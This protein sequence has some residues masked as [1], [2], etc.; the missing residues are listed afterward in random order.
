MEEAEHQRI[1]S[2]FACR[3]IA[4]R[5]NGTLRVNL[6]KS[7][8]NVT[9]LSDCNPVTIHNP[10][11]DDSSPS[12][13]EVFPQV[14]SSSEKRLPFSPSHL[15]GSG[16]AW[17]MPAR[18]HSPLHGCAGPRR[19]ALMDP[20]DWELQIQQPATAGR[21]RLE[22]LDLHQLRGSTEAKLSVREQ[23]RQ[24]EQKSLQDQTLKQSRDSLGSLSSIIFRDRQNDDILEVTSETLLSI[25]DYTH[26]ST[27]VGRDGPPMVVIT[28]GEESWPVTGHRPTP[29]ALRRLSSSISSCMTV[30]P[31]QI[32]VEIIPDPPENPPPPPPQRQRPPSP[33]TSPPS[34]PPSSPLLPS[35]RH[36]P[37]PQPSPAFDKQVSPP[38]PPP[39]PP[40]PSPA[41]DQLRPVVQFVPASLPPVSSLRPVSERKHPQLPQQSQTDVGRKKELKGIL[42]NIQNLA[43]I[44]RSVANMYSQVDKNCKVPKL[45]IKPQVTEEL[46][47]PNKLQ[48][49]DS[50]D[51]QSTPKA[52][53]PS[54]VIHVSSASVNSTENES[55]PLSMA[56]EVPQTGQSKPSTNTAELSEQLSSESTVF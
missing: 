54:S 14:A 41:S 48:S 45:K 24:F 12:S 19:Q 36:T 52:T 4:A 39:L 47:D 16:C 28:Q 37:T 27:G 5:S 7:E 51:E 11:Y 55:S 30:Q 34:S 56:E 2:T 1:L 15:A 53:N 20:D 18:I 13:P 38:T 6:P 40:P 31:C 8:S 46:E 33:P 50:W 29:P 32:T 23:A 9:L 26:S 3:T 10:V 43:D 22:S 44:E 49:S 35:N 42:K 17:S 21:P 25:L